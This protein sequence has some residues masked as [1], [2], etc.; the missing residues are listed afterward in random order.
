MRDGGCFSVYIVTNAIRTTLYTGVTS[1]LEGRVWEH[2]Q[3]TMPKSFTARYCCEPA[4]VVCELSH[5]DGG[6]CV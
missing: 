1:D 4:G 3:R 5:C 6:D 2:K